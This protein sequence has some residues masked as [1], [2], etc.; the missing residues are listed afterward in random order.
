[1]YSDFKTATKE[2]LLRSKKSLNH[3]AESFSSYD[4]SDESDINENGYQSTADKYRRLDSARS[5][6]EYK[7]M[8][9]AIIEEAKQQT[10]IGGEDIDID[11]A[12][13]KI[14][15]VYRG[16]KVRSKLQKE[17]E[18]ENDQNIANHLS[19]EFDEAAH[20]AATKI[21]ATFRG[22]LV[23]S[24]NK[25]GANQQAEATNEDAK[26]YNQTDTAEQSETNLKEVYGELDAHHAAARIQA[27]YRGHRVRSNGVLSSRRNAQNHDGNSI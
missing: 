22:H 12:A 18:K 19:P 7:M 23:R 25:F 21:Q 20:Q 6:R 15:S 8:E 24:S 9:E 16:H 27:M 10:A 11:H 14:Q 17:M 13:T 5:Y 26:I 2:I 3:S 1:M 4:E